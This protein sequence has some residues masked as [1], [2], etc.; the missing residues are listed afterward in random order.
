MCEMADANA[1]RCQYTRSLIRKML[2]HVSRWYTPKTNNGASRKDATLNIGYS[3]IASAS[4]SIS[5]SGDINRGTSTIVVAGRI[6]PK[7]C[8]WALPTFSQLSAI[9]TTYIRV[10]T[11]CCNEAP[12]RFRA[13]SILRSVW[14]VCA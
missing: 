12:D 1:I 7:S 8:P 6:S 14:S 4:I 5:M 11:T 9:L 2:N 3:I 13:A 10:R